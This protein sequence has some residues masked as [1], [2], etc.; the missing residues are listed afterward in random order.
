MSRDQVLGTIRWGYAA[1][2]EVPTTL[3]FFEFKWSRECAQTCRGLG[4]DATV[5]EAET[6]PFPGPQFPL[7]SQGQLSCSPSLL[8]C[9]PQS[10]EELLGEGATLMRGRSLLV[11]EIPRVSYLSDFGCLLP[12]IGPQ[13]QAMRDLS[14]LSPAS[15]L[16]ASPTATSQAFTPHPSGLEACYAE[17]HSEKAWG[18][19]GEYLLP[20]APHPPPP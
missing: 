1:A 19:P 14:L 8:S 15:H 18:H 6:T 13:P 10:L 5:C 9:H 4:C 20:Q 16:P 2:S 7:L 17:K 3:R 12:L 11:V